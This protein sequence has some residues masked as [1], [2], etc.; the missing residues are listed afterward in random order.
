MLAVAIV[1]GA[2]TACQILAPKLRVPALILLLP[3]GFALGWL[4]PDYRATNILGPVFPALVDL[5]VAIILFQGGLDLHNNPINRDDNSLVRRLVWVGGAI[6]LL[7]ASVAA[8]FIVG[9]SWS[10]AFM[11]GAIVIVSGPTVVT[12]ILDFAKVRGRVRNILQWEGT[13]L[14]PIGALVA[15]VV[16][17]IVKASGAESAG[18]AV[19][20]FVESLAV[21]VVAAFLGVVLLIVGG[22]LTR[23]NE[24]MGTQVLLGSVIVAAGLANYISDD[25]GLLAAL[26]MGMSAPR[27]AQRFGASLN[28]S[29]PFFGTLVS[30]GIGVLFI[31]IAGLVTPQSLGDV[32]VPVLLMSV[33]LIVLVRPLVVA[34][35]TMRTNLTSRQ[36][37]FMAAMDPRGIVAAA[38]A[39]SVGAALV[40]LKVPGAEQ[41]LPAAFVIVAVT[42]AFY[43]LSAIPVARALGIVS[44]ETPA[45]PGDAATSD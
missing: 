43:G 3:V 41:L 32:L 31:S 36:R 21:G 38:T 16:F 2:A 34:V 17:Q 18:A 6:T 5:I 45:A 24:L 15:V 27:I 4:A 9:L 10:I 13:L 25:T 11:L 26:L 39:S 1:V 19:G 30:I 22:R 8:H 7:G 35:C 40:S 23:G 37:L 20:L 42:V 29:G 33:I 44:D 14:D 12:P 28:K